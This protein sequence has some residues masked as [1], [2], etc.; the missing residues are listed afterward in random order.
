[1]LYNYLYAFIRSEMNKC[2]E[3]HAAWSACPRPCSTAVRRAV[4][5][6]SPPGA[7]RDGGVPRERVARIPGRV[8]PPGAG[9]AGLRQGKIDQSDDVSAGRGAPR[10][11]DVVADAGSTRTAE[12]GL[13]GVRGAGAGR[14]GDRGA[15]AGATRLPGTSEGA[16]VRARQPCGP[17]QPEAVA[18]SDGST[19][20]TEDV[21]S[22]W[23]AV[24]RARVRCDRGIPP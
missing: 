6:L 11:P 20:D 17:A 2:G 19:G 12:R 14:S 8:A 4:D 9:P 22:F 18:E 13:K 1:M 23:E 3:A 5:L 7:G 10:Y 16:G 21:M 24:R 15:V